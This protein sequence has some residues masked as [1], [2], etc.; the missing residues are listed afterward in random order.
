MAGSV[1]VGADHRGDDYCWVGR[2]EKGSEM[3]SRATSV[4]VLTDDGGWQCRPMYPVLFG[5]GDGTKM[6]ACQHDASVHGTPREDYERRVHYVDKHTGRIIRDH[7]EFAEKSSFF[8]VLS[9]AAAPAEFKQLCDDPELFFKYPVTCECSGA[10]DIYGNDL[11]PVS[12]RSLMKFSGNY[13]CLENPC[14]MTRVSDDFVNFEASKGTCVPTPKAL[15]DFRNVIL[16]DTRSPMAGSVPAAGL[17]LADAVARFDTSDTS[18]DYTSVN[19]KQARKITRLAAPVI[20]ASNLDN[21]NRSRHILYIPVPS[22]TLHWSS[23]R[24]S[25]IMHKSCLP[26]LTSSLRTDN[27]REPFA[28]AAFYV[29]P[30]ADVLSGQI[31]QKPYE[32]DLIAAESLRNSRM[33]SGNVF[34]GSELL[35]STLLG[36]NYSTIPPEGTNPESKSRIDKIRD[37]YNLVFQPRRLSLF[38]HLLNKAGVANHEAAKYSRWDASFRSYDYDNMGI[39]SVSDTFVMREGLILRSLRAV[40]RHGAVSQQSEKQ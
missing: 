10:R 40:R 24:P 8:D 35:F 16:G 36:G 17:V 34:G 33:I 28:T 30:V 6:T 22:M 23:V 32:H 2:S 12:S 31:P 26:P 5:G 27:F 1:L 38:E 29:E 18:L 14:V 4:L 11:L 37:F 25:A 21:T 15:T 3:C 20:P 9:A 19:E 7:N 13:E 39:D